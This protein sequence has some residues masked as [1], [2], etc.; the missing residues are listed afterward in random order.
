MVNG[1]LVIQS[2]LRG[3]IDMKLQIALSMVCILVSGSVFAQI[4][5]KKEKPR[6]IDVKKMVTN[7]FKTLSGYQSGDLITGGQVE[8]LIKKFAQQ[9]WEI[10]NPDLPMKRMIKSGSYLD[11]T[12]NS[13]KGKTFFRQISSIKNGMDRV[14]RMLSTK[15]GRSSIRQLVFEIPRGADYIKALATTSNGKLLGNR[16]NGQNFNKPTG[17]IYTEKQLT[18]YLTKLFEQRGNAAGTRKNQIVRGK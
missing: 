16:Q 2:K 14:E 18:E 9:G 7:H 13:R 15:N 10:A 3:S 6:K 17:K 12:M 8:P 4:D 1:Q 5:V 11:K